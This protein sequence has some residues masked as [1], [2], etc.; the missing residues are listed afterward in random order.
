[1]W[2]IAQTALAAGLAWYLAHDVLGHPEPFFAPIAAAVCLWATNVVRAELAVEMMIGVAVGI[3]L[4]TGVHAVLGTDPIAMGVV[5]L[6]ALSVAVVIGQG[7]IAQRPM[8]VNQTVMSAILILAFPHR[9]FGLERF[10]DALIGGG[11]AVVFSILVFPKNPLT[12]LRDA[13][14][15]MLTA[16]GDILDQIGRLTGDSPPPDPDWALAAAARLH[17]RLA[18]LADARS[19]AEQLARVCPRRWPL[20]SATRV[21]DRQAAQLALLAGSVLHLA[22][23]VTT[24]GDIGDV[25]RDAVGGLAAAV[26]ALADDQRAAT[27]A[28][29]AAVR[30]RS[31]ACH[32]VGPASTQALLA[33]IIDTCAD[34]LQ[35][36]VDL[37]P[38]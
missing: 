37:T 33:A 8:F 5:V 24:A 28:H 26:T 9:G 6:L 31:A 10:Y 27:A 30:R 21:A 16:L 36:V 29:A 1:M 20:R 25:L 7:F 19:T 15:D 18:R 4:G 23:T 12:V 11:L 35:R 38:R 32:S 13:R 34:E 3:G 14:R 17:R 22:R 2:P